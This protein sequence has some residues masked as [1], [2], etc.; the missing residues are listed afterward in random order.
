MMKLDRGNKDQSPHKKVRS[1]HDLDFRKWRLLFTSTML[2]VPAILFIVYFG[3]LSHHEDW[4]NNLFVVGSG[5]II[6]GCLTIQFFEIIN[7]DIVFLNLIGFL[8]LFF[9]GLLYF[10][11]AISVAVS[12]AYSHD[13]DNWNYKTQDNPDHKYTSADGMYWFGLQTF[14][15]L[16][17]VVLAVDCISDLYFAQNLR[18]LMWSFPLFWTSWIGFGYW[19]KYDKNSLTWWQLCAKAGFGTIAIA[20]TFLMILCALKRL[21]KSVG[22][23]LT[24]CAFLGSVLI[25]IY[26]GAIIDNW[27]T[28][29]H[30]ACL[31]IGIPFLIS[32]QCIFLLYD[33]LLGTKEPRD[34]AGAKT[35]RP[36]SNQQVPNGNVHANSNAS[37]NVDNETV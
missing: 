33:C 34:G 9:G 7:K 10:L 6:L 8:F 5:L 26:Y 28:K 22:T 18:I 20:I 2:L 15:A 31:Y 35:A 24:G 13:V 25:W 37:E 36:Y 21:I 14:F 17:A 1:N 23:L 3:N 16:D 30:I 29:A 27:V 32:G 19:L 11:C 12:M 4:K